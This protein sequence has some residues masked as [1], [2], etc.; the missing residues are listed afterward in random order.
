M[1]YDLSEK[2]S[3]KINALCLKMIIY[4]ELICHFEDDDGNMLSVL[5]C[6][7]TVAEFL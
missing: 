1:K 7:W 4:I 3:F 2:E 5:H 6:N